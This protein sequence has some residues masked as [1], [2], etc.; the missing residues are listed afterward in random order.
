MYAKLFN[1]LKCRPMEYAKST[2]KFWDDEHIS[3]YMLEAHL[4]PDIESA[5]RQHSFI[6]ASAKWIARQVKRPSECNLLDLGCGA[7]IYAQAFS[8]LGFH[9]TGIDF[10]K[11]SIDYAASQ[12]IKQNMGITYHYQ[13]YLEMEYE[14]EFDIITLIYCDFGVLPPKD[15]ALLL[16]KVKTALKPDGV[17]ILDGFTETQYKDFIE[18]RTLTY[19]EKGFWSD[20]PYMCI[21][22]NYCYDENKT[23]LE[24]YLVVTEEQLNCYNIWNQAFDSASLGAELKAAGFSELQFYANVCGESLTDK[25][26]TICVVGR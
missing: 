3:K 2:S 22:N 8:S 4:N 17:I 25:S 12:A 9:V 16:E 24:Q 11:R 5:S 21:Q 6:N 10:A 18:N 23:Y 20:T 7:G 15:R 1:Y 13:N 19:E 14:N 26:K